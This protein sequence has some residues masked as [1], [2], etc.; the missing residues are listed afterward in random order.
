MPLTR[1]PVIS[2]RCP[3]DDGAPVLRRRLREGCQDGQPDAYVYWVQCRSCA[4]QGPWFK[5]E[6]NAIRGW[7]TR[8]QSADRE[9]A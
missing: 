9:P 3:F 4:A 1:V 6:G 7:N 5:T 2:A 8:L